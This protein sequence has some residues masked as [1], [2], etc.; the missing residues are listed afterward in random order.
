[1]NKPQ[2]TLR[3]YKYSLIFGKILFQCDYIFF[4]K[5]LFQ[6][7]YIFFGQA[8]SQSFMMVTIKKL[9]EFNNL[10][11]FVITILA[12]KTRHQYTLKVASVVFHPNNNKVK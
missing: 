10:T 5:I 1:M 12:L 6:C 2:S 11:E 4:G 7:D 8:F 9:Q 3:Y